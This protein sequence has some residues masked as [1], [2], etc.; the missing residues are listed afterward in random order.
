MRGF[1]PSYALCPVAQNIFLDLA[2]RGLGNIGEDDDARRFVMC[3]VLAAVFDDFILGDAH[4]FPQFDEGARGFAP[5][6]IGFCDHGAG[7]DRRVFIEY[8]L[9]FDG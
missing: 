6:V 4:A 8:V 1:T 2:G 9:D 3:E 5:F 7:G